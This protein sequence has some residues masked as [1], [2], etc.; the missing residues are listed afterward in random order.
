[1]NHTLRHSVRSKCADLNAVCPDRCAAV[2]VDTVFQLV[3][4]IPVLER[5]LKVLICLGFQEVTAANIHRSKRSLFIRVIGNLDPAND[6]VLIIMQICPDA[7]GVE[8]SF[9][10]E[11]NELFARGILMIRA[12]LHV[13]SAVLNSREPRTACVRSE[14]MV[15]ALFALQGLIESAG[16][17]FFQLIRAAV[18]CCAVLKIIADMLRIGI[19][20]VFQC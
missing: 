6:I 10:S 18:L 16:G 17:T 14:L 20:A 3:V 4:C 12:V 15:F 5:Q 1:M 7:I 9:Q 13:A 8:I 19:C 11:R 2:I